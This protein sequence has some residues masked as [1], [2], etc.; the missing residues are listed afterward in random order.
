MYEI[1]F[2]IQWIWPI[3]IFILVTLAPESPWFLVRKGRLEEAKK[4]I[5]RLRSKS[6]DIDPN[7]VVA[8]MVRT[9]EIELNMHA[10]VSYLVGRQVNAF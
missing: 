5:V 3:P 2:A 8:M 1:P 10:G 4:S 9:N 7:A 6:L